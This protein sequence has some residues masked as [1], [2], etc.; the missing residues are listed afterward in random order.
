MRGRVYTPL[1]WQ[2]GSHTLSGGSGSGSGKRVRE[3]YVEYAN[4]YI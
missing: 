3:N 1:M 4:N 2:R